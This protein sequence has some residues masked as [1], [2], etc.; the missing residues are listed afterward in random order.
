M[1]YLESHRPTHKDCTWTIT[2]EGDFKIS[3]CSFK[4]RICENLL[5]NKYS[6][7]ICITLIVACGIGLSF[8][9]LL[10]VPFMFM[11]PIWISPVLITSVVKLFK[12]IFGLPT[13]LQ[14]TIPSLLA[15]VL[16]DDNNAPKR[17]IPKSIL[18]YHKCCSTGFGFRYKLHTQDGERI[19]FERLFKQSCSDSR[20]KSSASEDSQIGTRHELHDFGEYLLSHFTKQTRAYQTI[21]PRKAAFDKVLHRIERLANGERVG[22]LNSQGEETPVTDDSYVVLA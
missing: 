8:I 20:F 21:D 12:N 16:L 11:V 13:R 10:P 1:Q 3:S 5:S 15:D 22:L 7:P 14:I 19:V 6:I 2:K 17:A 18:P 9:P 4:A